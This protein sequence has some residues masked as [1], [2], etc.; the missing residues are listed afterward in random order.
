M[1]ALIESHTQW[2]VAGAIVF[3]GLVVY[4]FKDVIR[5][6]FKRAWAISKVAFSESIRRKVLWITPL[7]ILGVIAVSQLQKAT[8]EQDAIRQTIK[9]S[10]FATGLLVTVTA[11]I[12]ACTNLPK[13]IDTRVIYTIVTKPTTRLEIVV[14]KVI[15]FAKVSAAILLI[16]GLFTFAYLH[17][18]AWSMRRDIQDRLAAGSI[19]P[20]SRATYEYWAAN[21][22]LSSRSFARAREFQ[23]FSKPPAENSTVRWFFGGGEGEL[24]VPFKLSEREVALGA[25]PGAAG[26]A[27][28][29]KIGHAKSHYK[30]PAAEQAREQSLP[31]GVA[32][33]GADA[34]RIAINILDENFN[35][36]IDSRQLPDNGTAGLPDPTG[37]STVRVL[38]PPEVVPN[39]LR[40][41]VIWVSVTGST[42]GIE[43]FV[44]TRSSRDPTG[45]AVFLVAEG[46]N[47][48][49]VGISPMNNPSGEEVASPILRARMGNYGQQ[50]RGG[51][52]DRSPVAVFKFRDAVPGRSDG[53][54]GFEL[55]CGIEQNSDESADEVAATAVEVVVAK[56]GGAMSNPVTIYPENN[57]TCYFN[58][59]AP[60]VAGGEFDIH[61]RNSSPG[62]FVGLQ[63]MSIAMAA[64]T[65]SFNL[66]LAK[67]LGILWMLS[68]LVV[69]ISLFC[70]TF[71]SWPIAIVLTLLMLLGHW[72]VAQLSDTLAPG[73]GNQIATEMFGSGDAAQ[74]KVVSASV[75]AL[76]RL[77]NMVAKVLP[78]IGQFSAIESIEG[79]MTITGSQLLA[80]LLVLLAF[81]VPLLVL[82]YVI[83]CWKEVAP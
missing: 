66:N 18:R 73:I 27:V 72:G 80:P 40:S 43:Y 82:S 74:S 65:E 48:M 23:V 32:A 13:E 22:L 5:F 15:G 76:T 53:Q 63:R 49:Q 25:V 50:L 31:V 58:I 2:W 71:L 62:H 6:S 70:S 52:P 14:G 42:P 17:L 47:N 19:E 81:G 34:P 46:P 83:F 4:G 79:G 61:V 54:I 10:L 64:S 78:D 33:P 41:S 20:M 3:L 57:R 44:D 8:D 1:P 29:M 28:R 21:G 12:L 24:L 36:L 9:Y 26:I 60:E 69:I 56:P 16:M 30:D 38:L 35:S 55:K 39:L 7:A 75:E 59:P 37:Q 45:N 68:I 67:S 77:L 51:K 11:I